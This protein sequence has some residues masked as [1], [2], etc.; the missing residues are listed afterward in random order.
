M[1]F[2]ENLFAFEKAINKQLL[3]VK[4]R[5]EVTLLDNF[6]G[7]VRIEVLTGNY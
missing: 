1:L 5:F 4:C 6:G 3:F 2:L 7:Y